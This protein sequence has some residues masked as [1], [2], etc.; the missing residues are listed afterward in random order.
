MTEPDLKSL[1]ETRKK[2]RRMLFLAGSFLLPVLWL[3]VLRIVTLS[4]GENSLDCFYH[5]RIAEQ[6]PGT[7]LAREFPALQLSVWRDAFADK[8]WLYHFGLWCLS[9]IRKIFGWRAEAP[10]HFEAV[11]SICLMC[12]AFV[13]AARRSGVRARTLFAGSL[14][15]VML[16]VNSLARLE[17]LRPHVLSLTLLLI[18]FGLLAKGSLK[19]RAWALFGIS[20]LYAWSYS[21]PHF[22]V[23]AA[24]VWTALNWKTDS[25]RGLLLPAAAA[26]GVFLA[27]LIHPQTPNTLLIW[28]VQS[29]DA[30]S[31]PLTY[32]ADTNR[33]PSELMSPDGRDFVTAIP[34]FLIVFLNLILIVRTLE[35]RGRAGLSAAGA[36]AAVF[37]LIFAGAF[38][39]A[40]RSTEYAVPF[41]VLGFLVLADDAARNGVPLPGVRDWK[42]S[43]WVL[44]AVSVLTSGVSSYLFYARVHG[45]EFK[46]LPEL[47]RYLASEFKPGYALMN[48]DWSDFPRLYYTAPQLRWL[49]GLDPSFSMAADPRKTKLLTMAV[50]AER[51]YG[52]T[53][54]R[55]AVL[56][57]PRRVHARHLAACGWRLV[58]DIPGEAWIFRVPETRGKSRP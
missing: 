5:I 47:E 6:G 49:W 12:A 7:F 28:K 36:A 25:R 55:F 2:R 9:G 58:R 10:F 1:E 45:R 48:P 22:I 34:L 3:S 56:L 32:G 11:V 42:K 31:S 17:M 50:P 8:E 14:L 53:G 18:A 41:S 24:M 4:G 29:L 52:E 15:F 35:F 23:L 16:T 43:A 33:I 54:L 46:P 21:S 39:W 51:I 37:G 30:L 27:L 13:F 26:A 40:K 38:F 44:L 57:Y 20:F 19:F